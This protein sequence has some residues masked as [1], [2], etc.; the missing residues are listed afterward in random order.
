[1]TIGAT[2]HIHKKESEAYKAVLALQQL[3]HQQIPEGDS[4]RF[5]SEQLCPIDSLVRSSAVAKR[6]QLL[7]CIR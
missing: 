5:Y 7:F 3:H 2:F 1:M 4:D 6:M